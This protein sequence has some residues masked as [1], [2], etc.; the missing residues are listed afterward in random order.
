VIA[1]GSSVFAFSKLLSIFC[2]FVGP[3]ESELEEELLDEEL[4]DESSVTPVLTGVV[5]GIVDEVVD[6]M[7]CNCVVSLISLRGD[8]SIFSIVGF[9]IDIDRLFSL[10]GIGAGFSNG[11][12]ICV[13]VLCGAADRDISCFFLGL[14][15]FVI[16]GRTLVDGAF[17]FIALPWLFRSSVSC[18]LFDMMFILSCN[19]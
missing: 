19:F 2:T 8:S 7:S 12:M 9:A 17:F 13:R 5:D 4:E 6:V 10:G 14:S 16:E 11:D 1:T 3:S 15:G 18:L